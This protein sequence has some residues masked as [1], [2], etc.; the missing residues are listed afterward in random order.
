MIGKRE[1]ELKWPISAH[2]L[3][4]FLGQAGPMIRFLVR[5]SYEQAHYWSPTDSAK[6]VSPDT[7]QLITT[8]N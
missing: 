2:T 4:L 7:T 1:R 5:P 3:I 8:R 6:N